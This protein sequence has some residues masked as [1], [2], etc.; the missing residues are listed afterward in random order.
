MKRLILAASMMVATPAAAERQMIV[1]LDVPKGT[2]VSIDLD[3][4]RTVDGLPRA[5]GTTI[6]MAD[7][8]PTFS[9]TLFEFDCKGERSRVLSNTVFNMD[10]TSRFVLDAQPWSYVIPNTPAYKLMYY[11]CGGAKKDDDV[12]YTGTGQSF[13]RHFLKFRKDALAKK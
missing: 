4:I 11:G 13:A 5:W 12:I 3:T 2:A 8:I 7:D 9:A 1:S 10:G 6:M